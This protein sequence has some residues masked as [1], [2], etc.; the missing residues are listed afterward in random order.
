MVPY[1]RWK[2]DAQRGARCLC[3]LGTEFWLE[4]I[5]SSKGDDGDDVTMCP[6]LM[7]STCV[8][9]LNDTFIYILY[10]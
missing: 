9:W 7:L 8:L 10:I 4:K 2:V 1:M 3:L 6:C 5:E